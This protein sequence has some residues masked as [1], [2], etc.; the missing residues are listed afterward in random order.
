MAPNPLKKALTSPA[1]EQ[2]QEVDPRGPV[3]DN[4][5]Y[6]QAITIG[7]AAPGTPGS[8]P[9]GQVSSIN[10]EINHVQQNRN[11][12]A[13][14]A[15]S[16]NKLRSLRFAGQVPGGKTG[17]SLLGALP[18]IGQGASH[19]G[20]EAQQAFERAR[21]IEV[22][23]FKQRV[24]VNMSSEE[25]DKLS[26]SLLPAWNDSEKT[27]QEAW[28]KGIQ[29]FKTLESATQNLDQ[30]KL[31]TP[32]PELPYAPSTNLN[33]PSSGNTQAPQDKDAEWKNSWEF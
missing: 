21:N 9:E 29:H 31:K 4:N 27:S 32:F 12:Y 24:G 3:I 10:S 22:E 11:V 15:D 23:A 14:W 28:R 6:Q 13:D 20:A 8:I 1:Q 2:A 16:F 19:A 30:Y 26:N 33:A 18:W 5:K 17:A 25:K 7:R